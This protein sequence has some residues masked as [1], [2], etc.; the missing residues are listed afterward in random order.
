MY[1]TTRRSY[2]LL[3]MTHNVYSYVRRCLSCQKHCQHPTHQRSI[4]LF[5]SKWPLKIVA[6]DIPRPLPKN[7]TN[8]KVIVVI[9][10]RYLILTRAIPTKKTTATHVAHI[11]GDDWVVSYGILD[12][13]LTKRGSLFE[14]FFNAVCTRLST[15]ILTTTAYSPQTNEQIKRYSTTVLSRRR[16]NISKH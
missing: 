14:K 4:Q 9:N 16:Q 8:N 15:K 3:Y 2:Y 13:L 6:I 12:R 7:K 5:P 1:D 11:C 10:K